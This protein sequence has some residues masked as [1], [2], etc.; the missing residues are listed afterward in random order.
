VRRA[1]VK[2]TRVGVLV[3]CCIVA[4]A[5]AYLIVREVYTAL[6]RLPSLAPASLGL[7]A[8]VEGV[9]AIGT[10]NRL[11]GRPGTQP[12]EPMLVARYAALAKASSLVGALALGAYAGVLGY[13][14]PLRDAPQPRVDA[15][16]AGFGAAAGLAVVIAAY[17]LE[18]VCRVKTPKDGPPEPPEDLPEDPTAL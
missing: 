2:P 18:R 1:A 14:L 7:I 8:L 3:A 6:P 13:V 4:G 11:L 17:A 15:F 12:V 5:V 10:R 16:V 9:L